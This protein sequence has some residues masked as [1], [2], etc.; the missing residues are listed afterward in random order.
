M[1][2]SHPA[3][4]AK[5]VEA[6]D[7]LA[8]LRDGHTLAIGG[9][10]FHNKPMHLVREVIRRKVR[11]LTVIAVPQAS[12]DV[13]LLIA[14]GCVAE[15]R[16][17]YLGFEYLGLASNFRRHASEGRIR[18][19]SCDETQLL[20]GLEATAKNLP[21]GLVKTGVG[22]DLPRI[23][24]DLKEIA[25]PITGEPMIA[26]A[27]IRP[28]VALLHATWGDVYGNLAYAGFA[29]GDLPIAEA[30]S[31]GGGTVV[32]QVDEIVG[33]RRFGH[34]PFRTEVPHFLVDHVVEAPFG[35]Y[36]CSS[37]G[38]Y[39][40]DDAHLGDYVR[41]SRESEENVQRYLDDHCYGVATQADYL[42]RHVKPS[43]LVELRRAV[44]E[45]N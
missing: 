8:G 29:F 44:H 23:N 18:V 36:P 20:A 15:V 38:H 13:D 40:Y 7:V 42:D 6:G 21:S 32:A 33:N 22:T 11:G 43:R 19:W 37:H 35:A 27:A 1:H 16:V 9:S 31:R 30:T 28:D 25:D 17:P 3:R 24:R 39:Q 12:I 5:N 2:E 41:L 26:V 14:A 45:R 34:D 10:L 4:R